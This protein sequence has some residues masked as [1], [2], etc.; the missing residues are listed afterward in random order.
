RV[1]TLLGI[2]KTCREKSAKVG[3]KGV[4]E[5]GV[6]RGKSKGEKGE[7]MPIFVGFNLFLPLFPLGC[8]PLAD[9]ELESGNSQ[10]T[11]WRHK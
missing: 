11:I 8:S 6:Q 7:G 4:Q 10:K 5:R 9:G 1:C 2:R 3:K